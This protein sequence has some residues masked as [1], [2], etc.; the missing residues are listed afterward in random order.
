MDI[1][2]V[3]D[4]G[5]G[6]I[7]KILCVFCP[8]NG[9]D[10]I[11][12]HKWFCVQCDMLPSS[13]MYSWN[14]GNFRK[15]LKR[16]H[17]IDNNNSNDTNNNNTNKNKNIRKKFSNNG[18]SD[19]NSNVTFETHDIEL[20]SNIEADSHDEFCRMDDVPNNKMDY[21]LSIEFINEFDDTVLS[22]IGSDTK[23]I[24]YK[25]LCDQNLKLCDSAN[26]KKETKRNMQVKHHDG[27]TYKVAVHEVKSDGSCLF[28]T[29]VHQLFFSKIDSD[30]HHQEAKILRE[31]VV[32]EIQ[33]NYKHY[34]KAI[35]GRILD[36]IEDNTE[37]R[38]N[39]NSTGDEIEIACSDYVNN[40]L[41]NSRCW[42]GESILAFTEIHKVN[43]LV[44]R[45]HNGYYF[46]YGFNPQ[47]SRTIFMAYRKQEQTNEEWIYNHYGSVCEL[48]T[49]LLYDCA[50]ELTKEYDT[51]LVILDD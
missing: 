17:L 37:K 34:E 20:V 10:N 26:M 4:T 8:C 19:S 3:D 48:G 41:L 27:R 45:E 50:C 30:D 12:L 28:R 9:S 23:T 22:L 31:K 7:G 49:D 46:P 25:Q 29:A 40:R 43:V 32:E 18:N 42:A 13:T 36:D 44:F 5:D 11:L 2:K 21:E 35:Q 6:F 51:D 16:C 47:Y 24:L 15:H 14:F 33:N 39:E 38:S 1:A